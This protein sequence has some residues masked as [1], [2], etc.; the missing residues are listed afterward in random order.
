MTDDDPD[1]TQIVSSPPT[2]LKPAADD[3]RTVFG[4][5]P[6]VPET[7]APPAVD[8]EVADEATAPPNLNLHRN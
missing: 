5:M 1:K 7:T 3:D 4:G 6:I 8:V 2:P